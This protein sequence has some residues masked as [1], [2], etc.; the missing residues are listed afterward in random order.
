[1]DQVDPTE[2]LGPAPT[3]R[4]F[5]FPKAHRIRKRPDFLH[6]QRH[7]RRWTGR[8][9]LV[10]VHR[11][12]DQVTRFGFTVSRKVGNAVVR[13]RVRR[14]L[15]EAVRLQRPQWPEGRSVVVIARPAA[16]RAT[17]A[18]LERDILSWLEAARPA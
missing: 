12:E 15:R 11:A 3:P 6:V 17:Y 4:A 2:G 9:V 5:A 10:L 13:N 14:R 16:A 18:E 7:G 1:M 8:F